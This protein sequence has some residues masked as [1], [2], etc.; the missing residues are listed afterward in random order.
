MGEDQGERRGALVDLAALDADPPVLDHVDA[1]PAV[2]ADRAAEAL[3]QLDQPHRRAV[4]R[5]GD[6]L[7][8]GHHDLGPFRGRVLG[9]CG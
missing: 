6:A 7:V 1:A 9:R 2:V 4:E 3:D 8:E 5:N